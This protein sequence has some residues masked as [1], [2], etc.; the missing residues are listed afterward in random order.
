MKREIFYF[1][2]FAFKFNRTVPDDDNHIKNNKLHP[3]VCLIRKEDYWKIGGCD[4]DFVG[5]YGQTDPHFWYRAKGKITVKEKNNVY[6]LYY[7]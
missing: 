7:P 1:S 4:E 6:L 3:A 2:I 5:N